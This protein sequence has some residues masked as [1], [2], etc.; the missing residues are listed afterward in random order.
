M[1]Q[2]NQ[3]SGAAGSATFAGSDS[4][5]YN[6]FDSQGKRAT[7]YED[8]TVDVQPDP[9]RHLLQG[10]IMSFADGQPTYSDKVTALKSSDWHV[11]RAPDQEWSRTHYQRQSH[12][13]NTIKMVV[14]NARSDGAP[15]RFDPGWVSVLQDQFGALKHAEFGLGVALMKAQRDGMTQMI[16]NT[17]L[18]NASYK[19]RLAQDITLYL[20]DIGL[21]IAVDGDAGKKAW[22]ENTAWQGVRKVVEAILAATDHLEIY[23]AVNVV[24]EALVGELFRN[25]FIM[26]AGPVHNDFVTPA[27][28][29]AASS[30]Y[31]QNLANTLTLLQM[32]VNDV[33]HG[34]ANKKTMTG[35]LEK[36]VPLCTEAVG[37]LKAVW[38]LQANGD[39][40]FDNVAAEAKHRFNDIL[41]EIQIS[42]PKGATL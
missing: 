9:T 4:R 3:Q 33:K 38:I 25:G 26:R 40:K 1:T 13:E 39:L 32:L 30:D 17:I 22:L 20:G 35:W 41:A 28:V 7:L 29:S 2:N 23:F 18:T 12:I 34:D 14:E 37:R 15:G 5:R 10:W 11:F 27:V 36:Y 16:N 42:L 31:R 8:V 19:L 6:Y 21:D 24:F